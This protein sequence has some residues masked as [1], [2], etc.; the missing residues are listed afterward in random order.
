MQGAAVQEAAVQGSGSTSEHQS[1]LW[2]L[3]GQ[4]CKVEKGRLSALAL[5]LFPCV[6][7]LANT[8]VFWYWRSG[9]LLCVCP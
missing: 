1:F 7:L 5:M 2:L 6:L 3:A 9:G 4:S 8:L